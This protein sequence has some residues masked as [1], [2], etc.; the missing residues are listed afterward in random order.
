MSKKTTTLH[1]VNLE[2]DRWVKKCCTK[3][4]RF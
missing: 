2:Y 3:S 4:R 1:D